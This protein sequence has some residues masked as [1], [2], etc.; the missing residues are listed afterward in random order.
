MSPS[1]PVHSDWGSLETI[2]DRR[3][4]TDR[5]SE[6]PLVWVLKT[7]VDMLTDSLSDIKETVKRI[8]DV[9]SVISVIEVN[10]KQLSKDTTLLSSSVNELEAMVHKLESVLREAIETLATSNNT[11]IKFL[12]DKIDSK[13]ASVAK[14]NEAKLKIATDE[15]S[16]K[17]NEIGSKVSTLRST[18]DEN[19]NIARGIKMAIVAV[20]TVVS[21]GL[22]LY[23]KSE[24]DRIDQTYNWVEKY[25]AELALR[26]SLA[27]KNTLPL[28]PSDS[29]QVK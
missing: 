14:L 3:Q 13:F 4:G 6:D 29:T 8:A 17:I 9:V 16:L 12:N 11:N 21:G 22:Y 24:V 27:K 18:W 19:V 1:Q 25:K 28:N 20:F 23:V 10:A 5:R 2:T 15:L 7:K 26:E